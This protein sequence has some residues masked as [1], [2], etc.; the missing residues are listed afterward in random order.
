MIRLALS[1]YI[2]ERVKPYFKVSGAIAVGGSS[3]GD[4]PAT[5][6]CLMM[7]TSSPHLGQATFKGHNVETRPQQG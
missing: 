4:G 1:S 5:E 2:E 6:A 3:A 7:S